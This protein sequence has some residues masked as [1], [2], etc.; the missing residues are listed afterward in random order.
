MENLM[1]YRM[2]NG[3]LIDVMAGDTKKL[4]R[5]MVE[6]TASAHIGPDWEEAILSDGRGHIYDRMSNDAD[7]AQD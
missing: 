5:E 1:Q 6:A 3:R 7:N 4:T 2:K